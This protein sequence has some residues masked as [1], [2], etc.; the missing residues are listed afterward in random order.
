MNPASVQLERHNQP[1]E[2]N[3]SYSLKR[4]LQNSN[5][6]KVYA[7][8]SSQVIFIIESLKISIF[9]SRIDNFIKI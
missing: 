2:N 1:T 6:P 9:Q 3:Y 8:A 4:M 7:E 5:G